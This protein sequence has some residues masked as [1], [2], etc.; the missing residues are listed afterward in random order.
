V[1][2]AAGDADFVAFWVC[3]KKVLHV[4]LQAKGLFGSESY[5][6]KVRHL[7]QSTNLD[8]SIHQPIYAGFDLFLSCSGCPALRSRANSRALATC[9]RSAF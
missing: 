2:V 7:I 5:P 4:H 9:T 1:I 6:I 3:R 8:S